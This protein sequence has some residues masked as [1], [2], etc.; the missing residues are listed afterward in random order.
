MIYLVSGNRRLFES[1]N[2]EILSPVAAIDII[3]S[4]ELTQFDSET[5]GRDAHICNILCIQFGNRAANTQIVVDTETTNILLFKQILETKL[6]IGHNLKF[7]IQFLY[8]YNII[9]TKIWDTM[10]IEQ[11]LHLGFNNKF[12]HNFSYLYFFS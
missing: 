6:L 9:P 10:I 12:F 5:S 4:W 3:N 11:L 2:Y 8:N 1:E 7:D